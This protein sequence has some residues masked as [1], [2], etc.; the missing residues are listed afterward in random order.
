MGKKMIRR[1]SWRA[2]FTVEAVFIV[3]LL[4][5]VIVLLVDMALYLRDLSAAETLAVRVAEDTRALILND[6]EPRLHKVMYERKLEQSIFRRWFANTEEADAESMEE[7]LEELAEGRFWISK[8]EGHSVRAEDDRVIVHISLRS[9]SD[10]PL[11]GKALV[12]KWFS[13]DVTCSVNCEDIGL[14]TRIYS[15]VMETGSQITGVH[16]VLQKLSEI[17]NRLQ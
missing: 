15:A 6:E 11:F 13:D 8:I 16:T 4:T 9:D 14:R 7:Y 1:C 17:V 3:P 5:M 10:I 12:S 2:S